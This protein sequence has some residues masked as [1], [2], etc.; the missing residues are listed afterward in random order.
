MLNKILFNNSSRFVATITQKIMIFSL[1]ITILLSLTSIHAIILQDINPCLGKLSCHDCIQTKGCAFCSEE[2]DFSD[3]SRC[4][5]PEL[6]TTNER[7]CHEN[8]TINPDTE[9]K[10]EINNEL[11]RHHISSG[12]S[13]TYIS[14]GGIETGGSSYS[15]SFGGY[16]ESSYGSSYNKHMKS[17]QGQVVQVSPQKMNLKLRISKYCK[18]YAQFY[19]FHINCNFYCFVNFNLFY[20]FF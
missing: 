13:G 1:L 15:S 10:I 18:I 16:S 7:K 4:F 2:G 12:S 9:I 8:Y 6:H 17:S 3:R 5:K 19:M 20:F 14:G 11:T